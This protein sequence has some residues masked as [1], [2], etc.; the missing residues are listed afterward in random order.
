[1][2]LVIC[3]LPQSFWLVN[4]KNWKAL[5]GT[6]ITTLTLLI[7][8]AYACIRVYVYRESFLPYTPNRLVPKILLNIVASFYYWTFTSLSYRHLCYITD[9]CSHA[10]K[11]YC[12]FQ[13]CHHFSICPP[14]PFSAFFCSSFHYFLNTS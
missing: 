14:V 1:M 7:I 13:I 12:L 8:R 10:I 3:E 5:N 11:T 9:R 4:I 6:F 2:P